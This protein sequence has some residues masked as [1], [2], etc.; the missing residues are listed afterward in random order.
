[1]ETNTTE[2]A[3]EVA[4]HPTAVHDKHKGWTRKSAWAGVATDK[5]TAE[6]YA[7][8]LRMRGMQVRVVEVR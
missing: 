7:T 1:M 2:Y 4:L 8:E 6:R 5:A 3:V